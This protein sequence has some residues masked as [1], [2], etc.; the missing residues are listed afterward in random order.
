MKKIAFLLIILS[1]ILSCRKNDHKQNDTVDTKMEGKVILPPGSPVEVNKLTILS[2][3]QETK[4]INGSYILDTSSDLNFSTQFVINSNGEPM[5]MRYYYPSMPNGD[6]TSQSTALA[7]LMNFPSTSSLSK[8][9][10][11][12]LI[13]KIQTVPAFKEVSEAIDKFL[14]KGISFS[15]ATDSSFYRSLVKMF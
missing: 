15:T 3:Q 9:G 11:L 5:L 8:E 10:K 12:N 4:I 2:V 14:L 1:S 7:I 13:N 6:I